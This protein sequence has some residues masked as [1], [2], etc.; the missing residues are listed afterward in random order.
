VIEA[1]RV[2]ES[3]AG[4]VKSEVTEA[5]AGGI[6]LGLSGGVDSAVVAA[7]AKRAFPDTHLALILPLHTAAADVDDARR[8]VDE[9]GLK[10]KTIELDPVYDSLAR[11]LGAD[12][13]VEEQPDLALANLKARLRMLVLYYHANRFRYLV[14]GTG[15]RSQLSIGYFTKFGDGGADLMPLGHLVKSEVVELARYLEVPQTVI[16]KPPSADTWRG[17]TD[18]GELGFTYEQLEQYVLGSLEDDSVRQRITTLRRNSSHKLRTPKLPPP[19]SA[20]AHQTSTTD[21]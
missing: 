16:E 12:P 20:M 17:H 19:T 13:A 6:I 7:L 9:F 4:W 10:A 3:L 8:V 2:A 15:N 11:I 14:A 5:G 18:E 21:S 1:A